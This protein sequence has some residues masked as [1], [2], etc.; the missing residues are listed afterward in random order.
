MKPRVAIAG[1]C[2]FTLFLSAHAVAVGSSEGFLVPAAVGEPIKYSPEFGYITIPGA[3]PDLS[4]SVQDLISG[5]KLPKP[6]DDPCLPPLYKDWH[7]LSLDY[8]DRTSGQSRLGLK[9]IIDRSTFRLTMESEGA[10][11]GD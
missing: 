4:I 5:Q 10:G 7:E 6:P 3:L 2:L 9:I 11:W 1:F 8:M